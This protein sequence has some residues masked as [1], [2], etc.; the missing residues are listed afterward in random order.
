MSYRGHSSLRLLESLFLIPKILGRLTS[1]GRGV[2]EN[3]RLDAHNVPHS[4]NAGIGLVGEQVDIVVLVS[5][6]NVMLESS[7]L[8]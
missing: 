8:D 6:N 7:V 2:A 3:A 4:R 1:I 5:H